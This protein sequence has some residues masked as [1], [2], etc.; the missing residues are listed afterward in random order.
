MSKPSAL[1]YYKEGNDTYTYHWA[2]SCSQNK[3]PANGW[4]ATY[5]KP[6][7]REQCNECKSK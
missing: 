1:Y 3:Y 6:P 2:K 5:R 7:G 4:I